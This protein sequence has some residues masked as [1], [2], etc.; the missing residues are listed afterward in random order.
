[1]MNDYAALYRTAC[2]AR[3]AELGAAV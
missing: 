1:M 3:G 2:V